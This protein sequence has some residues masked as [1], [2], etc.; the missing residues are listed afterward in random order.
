MAQQRRGPEL[1]CVRGTR[2][3]WRD[4]E[5]W[6]RW[7]RG[8]DQVLSFP[9]AFPLTSRMSSPLT[10]VLPIS[11]LQ[12]NVVFFFFS[13]QCHPPFV[14]W[15]EIKAVK[16]WFWKFTWGKYKV[17]LLSLGRAVRGLPRLLR[18]AQLMQSGLLRL[19]R[20]WVTAMAQCTST[21]N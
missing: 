2:L 6:W 12:R 19:P 5:L 3:L 8:V 20:L 21:E 7:E 14:E 10:A 1:V 13:E 4:P 9:L 15:R 17:F 11:L 18:G 16:Y